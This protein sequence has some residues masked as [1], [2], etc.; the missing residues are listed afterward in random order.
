MLLFVL[1]VQ[2]MAVVVK[3]VFC[4]PDAHSQAGHAH[5]H[6]HDG[7]SGASHHHPG[8]GGAGGSHSDGNHLSCHNV[9]AA[10]PTFTP[11]LAP[12]AA[13]ALHSSLTPL[14]ECYQPERLLRPPLS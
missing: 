9:S 14:S 6:E 1:P 5:H 8:D 11:A 13:P 2:G 3:S 4:G 7:G 12:E 10:M